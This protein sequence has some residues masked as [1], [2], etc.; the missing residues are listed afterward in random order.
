MTPERT[1]PHEPRDEILMKYASGVIDPGLALLVE[2]HLQRAP[3]TRKRLD[4]WNRL[5]GEWLRCEEPMDMTAGSL[6]RALAR[7]S[8]AAP[9][10]A[11]SPPSA[12][13]LPPHGSW[14]WAGAGARI[15]P[16]R[17]EGARTK[18]FLLRIAPGKAMVHHGHSAR[19]WTVLLEGSYRDETGHFP[20]GSFI[21]EDSD[22]Q[23]R[24]VV[25]SDVDCVCLIAMEG[26]I[27]A[28]GLAGA[29][30]RWLMR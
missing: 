22:H 1:G 2:A 3:A 7:L 26:P 18:L 29:A 20:T 5:G 19:E 12:R 23:H 8:D 10:P 11:A 17:V 28:P 21:E 15:A 13:P 27:R 30:A 6:D 9:A 16:V 14:R 24:P 25:D 4:M